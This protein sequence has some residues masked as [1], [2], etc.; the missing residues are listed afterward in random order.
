[1]DGDAKLGSLRHLNG[2]FDLVMKNM[3]A[4]TEVFLYQ[5]SDTFSAVC[6]LLKL[7]N[8]DTLNL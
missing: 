2:I 4:I 8:D 6:V 5:A 1:M 7:G 3:N